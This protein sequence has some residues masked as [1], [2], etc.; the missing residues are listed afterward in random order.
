MTDAVCC[1]VPKEVLAVSGTEKK[2]GHHQLIRSTLSRPLRIL[3]VP[4]AARRR[5]LAPTP[6]RRK[7]IMHKRKL[8]LGFLLQENLGIFA[9]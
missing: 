8:H 6:H 5:L 7:L 9:S 3:A 1:D 2:E 4:M